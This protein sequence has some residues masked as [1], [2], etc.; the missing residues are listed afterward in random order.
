MWPGAM[1]VRIAKLSIWVLVHS[2]AKHVSTSGYAGLKQV[3]LR[4]CG[5]YSKALL[6]HCL[7]DSTLC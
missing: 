3:Q 7:R 2:R 4:A 6:M 1:I 5:A